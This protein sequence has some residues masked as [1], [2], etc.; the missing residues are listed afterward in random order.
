M[1]TIRSYQPSDYDA[2]WDLHVLP[3]IQ[4][5]AY[6]GDGPWD[7]DLRDIPGAYLNSGGVFLIAEYE[8]RVVAMGAFRRESETRAE[9][10][11]MRTH[12]DYQ[13]RG[14]GK[15]ILA[16]LEAEARRLG[17]TSLFLETAMVLHVAQHMYRSHG[18]VETHRG[19][20]QHM[21]CIWFE[22]RL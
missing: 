4:V 5:S 17:I 6:L 22:K 13:G 9:I 11:R 2:V 18:F 12:L 3:M 8:G 19:K 1:L 7:D 15:Q 21:D 10:K 14:F 16:A 20:V